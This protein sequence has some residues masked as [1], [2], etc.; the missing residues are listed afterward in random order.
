MCL[1]RLLWKRVLRNAFGQACLH[2]GVKI[3]T[4]RGLGYY[5]QYPARV[6]HLW[7]QLWTTLFFK[8]T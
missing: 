4:L 8:H 2:G 6:G 7:L 3:L 1:A 5:V